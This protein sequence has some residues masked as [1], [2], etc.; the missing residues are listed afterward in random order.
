[1]DLLVGDTLTARS[2]EVSRSKKLAV[3]KVRR[4]FANAGDRADEAA[5]SREPDGVADQDPTAVDAGPSESESSAASGAQRKA[6]RK[7]A[8]P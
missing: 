8:I 2:V 4:V 6:A 7:S 5:I 1:M 3:Y